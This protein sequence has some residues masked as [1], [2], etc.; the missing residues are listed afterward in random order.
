MQELLR[1]SDGERGK[2]ILKG[3]NLRSQALEELTRAT[4]ASGDD[5]EATLRPSQRAHPVRRRLRGNP[6]T[7]A[8]EDC[9]S[10]EE[11]RTLLE[12]LRDLYER[13]RARVS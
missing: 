12:R 8:Q 6:V 7:I 9:T 1:E 13:L 2:T 3:K 5:A 10:A 11:R 4:A